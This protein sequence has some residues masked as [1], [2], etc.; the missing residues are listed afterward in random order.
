LQAPEDAWNSRDPDRVPR[1][2]TEDET[3]SKYRWERK[4]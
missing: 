3:D 2:Y 1:A 4:G